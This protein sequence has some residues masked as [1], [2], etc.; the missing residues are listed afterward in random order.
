MPLNLCR[1]VNILSWNIIVHFFT[2]QLRSTLLLHHGRLSLIGTRS[3]SMNFVVLMFSCFL[4]TYFFY[5]CFLILALHVTNTQTK[6]NVK[7]QVFLCYCDEEDQSLSV[8]L[9]R[10]LSASGVSYRCTAG[11]IYNTITFLVLG[12]MVCS[13]CCGQNTFPRHGIHVNWWQILLKSDFA[14]SQNVSEQLLYGFILIPRQL[15]WDE[16]TPEGKRTKMIHIIQPESLI[17]RL[18]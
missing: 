16:A 8:N 12:M 15:Q 11:M 18:R 17:W 5:K 7:W 14:Q 3:S 10:V 6:E 9:R 1:P 2:K 13:E 4:L